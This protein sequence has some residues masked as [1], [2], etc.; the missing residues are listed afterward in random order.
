LTVLSRKSFKRKAAGANIKAL[1]DA[2]QLPKPGLMERRAS[3]QAEGRPRSATVSQN[4]SGKHFAP[5]C[6]AD[7]EME[8]LPKTGAVV[9]VDLGLKSFAVASDGDTFYR[10]G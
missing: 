5:G 8:Q 7:A 1:D 2:V 3:K 6:R 4:P 9:G 10:R